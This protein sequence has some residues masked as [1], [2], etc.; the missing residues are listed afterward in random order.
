MLSRAAAYASPLA[1]LYKREILKKGGVFHLLLYAPLSTF[2]S[3]RVLPVIMNWLHGD[4]KTEFVG[5]SIFAC[6]VSRPAKLSPRFLST[7]FQ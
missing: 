2:S 7:S 6:S 1:H 3:D 4:S 5:V